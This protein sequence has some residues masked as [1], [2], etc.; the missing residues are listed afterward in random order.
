RVH[1]A[2]EVA[3]SLPVPFTVTARA[4]NFLHGRRDFDDTINRLQAFAKAGADVLYAPG[5][6]SLEEMRTVVR[7][8]SKPINIVMGFGD[9]N[10]TLDQLGEIGVRRVSIG[11]AFSRIALRSFM[12][13]A[14]EMRAGKFQ[15]VTRMAPI[16]EIHSAFV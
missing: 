12:E 7:A 2:A 3:K 5:L 13:A 9:P 4:E 11:G 1:A 16:N 6:R 8:V 10:I 15:F 14:R